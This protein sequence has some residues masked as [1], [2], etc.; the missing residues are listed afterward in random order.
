MGNVGII[1]KLA[2]E[3]GDTDMA[4]VAE[5]IRKGMPEHIEINSLEKKPFVFGLFTLELQ[6][7]M[8]DKKGGGDQLED[9][10]ENLEGIGSVE[11]LSQTLID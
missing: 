9:Y 3:D 5:T 8:D 4:G 11:V 2:P 6:V 10:L 7:I 1:Y